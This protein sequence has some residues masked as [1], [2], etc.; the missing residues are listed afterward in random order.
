M[1]ILHLPVH[2][3]FTSKC[4]IFRPRISAFPTIA[5]AQ[6]NQPGSLLSWLAAEHNA[7]PIPSLERAF[8]GEDLG[9]GLISHTDVPPEAPL[10]TIPMHL[11]VTSE[12][13]DAADTPWSV[14]MAHQLLAQLDL[15]DTSL[16]VPWL[17]ALPA[18]IPLPW[19]YWSEDEIEE[20]QDEDTI[21]E[22]LR[23]R[24]MFS[25]A[26]VDSRWSE[27]Q[28]AWA[29]SVVHSRSFIDRGVHILVPGIDLCNHSVTRPTA[30]VRTVYSPGACQGSAATEEIAPPGVGEDSPSRFELVA[31]DAGI[32]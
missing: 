14:H 29:L 3:A 19:L 13:A 11:A 6:V 10:L 28:L 12:G 2:R 16:I 8:L 9:Y 31:G 32:R 7:V 22:A 18:H 21:R 17:E 27:E 23:L 15:G 26:V 1:H 4:V 30:T 24:A 5:A 25:D 20:L